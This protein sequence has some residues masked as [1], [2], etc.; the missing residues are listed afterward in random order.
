MADD[1]VVGRMLSER[2]ELGE[3]GRSHRPD[4][5]PAPLGVGPAVGADLERMWPWPRRA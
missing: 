3:G 1:T 2:E 5:T 4:P